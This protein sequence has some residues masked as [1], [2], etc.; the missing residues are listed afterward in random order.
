[1]TETATGDADRSFVFNLL[2]IPHFDFDFAAAVLVLVL[3]L[4]HSV[5]FFFSIVSKM[6]P[7]FAVRPSSSQ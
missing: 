4:A 1:M 6:F 3:V 7:I 2:P 5:T